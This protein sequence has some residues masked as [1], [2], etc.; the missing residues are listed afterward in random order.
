MRD[1]DE[2]RVRKDPEEAPFAVEHD[3]GREAGCDPAEDRC[4]PDEEGHDPYDSRHIPGTPDD[5]PVSLGEDAPDAAD[6]RI[7]SALELDQP[8]RY[9]M[10]LPQGASYEGETTGEARAAAESRD[11]RKWGTGAAVSDA[12]LRSAPSTMDAENVRAEG[13]TSAPVRADRLDAEDVDDVDALAAD[14]E[15]DLWRKQEPLV[16]ED[17]KDSYN[18]AGIPEDEVQDVMEAMGDDA[19]EANPDLPEGTSATGANSP[20]APEHGGFPERET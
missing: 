19:E 9:G 7:E 5:V 15:R 16:E 6:Q 12:A 4:A 13:L 2:E 3:E 18:L 8:P 1:L 17:E 20:L 11:E 10:P 14:D